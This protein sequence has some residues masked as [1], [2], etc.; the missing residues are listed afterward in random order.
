LGLMW[1]SGAAQMRQYFC[2]ET[3]HLPVARSIRP[4]TRSLLIIRPP[5]LPLSHLLPKP[6]TREPPAICLPTKI[7]ATVWEVHVNAFAAPRRRT[8]RKWQRRRLVAQEAF[9]T[10]PPDSGAH[11]R[12]SDNADGVPR[13]FRGSRRLRSRPHCE[14]LPAESE[15][16]VV[17]DA[18]YDPAGSG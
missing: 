10:Q 17:S 2:R 4:A 5:S 6:R 8:L 16:A 14:L 12:P 7:C 1:Y 3:L 18:Q 9:I 13:L 15:P 11:P